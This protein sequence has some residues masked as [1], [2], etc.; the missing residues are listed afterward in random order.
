MAALADE[1][2]QRASVAHVEL[3]RPWLAQ[4]LGGLGLEI[5]PSAANFLLVGFPTHRGKTASE[6]EAFLASRGLLVRGV[7]GYGLPNHLR[8][9][10]GLEAHNRALIDSLTD[11]LS[12]KD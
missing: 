1:D 5:T 9:T 10:V 7:A 12:Q 11:F 2:F 3:W 6:A 4:Q 8:I